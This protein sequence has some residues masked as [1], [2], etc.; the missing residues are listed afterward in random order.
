MTQTK[1]GLPFYLLSFSNMLDLICR[2]S[3]HSSS[4]LYFDAP[5]EQISYRWGTKSHFLKLFPLI[6]QKF[7]ANF[8]KFFR[9]LLKNFPQIPQKFLSN[10]SKIFYKFIKNFPQI[11]QTFPANFSK[12]SHNFFKN[13]PQISQKLHANFSK[14]S[15]KF[16]KNFFQTS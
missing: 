12:T 7:P 14:T 6:S 3:V 10:S 11:S 16:L 5:A 8:S 1:T 13:F 4:L 9:K 15:R 2:T